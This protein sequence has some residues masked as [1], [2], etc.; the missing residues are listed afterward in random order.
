MQQS[1]NV[2][3]YR[4]MYLLTVFFILYAAFQETASSSSSGFSAHVGTDLFRWHSPASA[5][6]FTTVFEVLS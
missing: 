1:K 6:I 4:H 3:L 5:Y 2:N